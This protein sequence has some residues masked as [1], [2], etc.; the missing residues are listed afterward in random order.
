MTLRFVDLDI[1]HRL[2]APGPLGFL[3]SRYR[4]TENMMTASWIMAVSRDPAMIAVAIHPDRLSHQYVSQ[5]EFFGLSIPTADLLAAIQVAGYQSG[6][7][8]D[9]FDATGLTPLDPLE[10]EAPLVEEAVGH[11]ESGLIARQTFGDH[12]LFIGEVLAVRADSEAFDGRWLVEVDAGR[13][14]HHLGADQYATLS[15][16]YRLDVSAGVE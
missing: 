11:I 5:S 2:F 3:T 1:A 16:P 15:K 14:L 7:D 4:S 13:V 6:R 9:K 12:D 8:I 10:I